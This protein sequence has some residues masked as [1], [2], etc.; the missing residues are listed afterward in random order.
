GLRPIKT[1]KTITKSLPLV[2]A[3]RDHS[4]TLKLLFATLKLLSA[5]L[6]IKAEGRTQN[7][8]SYPQAQRYPI[9]L[10]NFTLSVVRYSPRRY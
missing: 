10:P 7:Y 9:K 3:R 1:A 6:T 5:T 2:A 4:T 8:P